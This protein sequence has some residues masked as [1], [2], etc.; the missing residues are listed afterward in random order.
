MIKQLMHVLVAATL[1][2]A[3]CSDRTPDSAKATEPGTKQSAQ[4]SAQSDDP[5]LAKQ[6]LKVGLEKGAEW[7]KSRKEQEH[8]A[9][10]EGVVVETPREQT[11]DSGEKL[12]ERDSE[13]LAT[14]GTAQAPGDSPPSADANASASSKAGFSIPG[15]NWHWSLW[16]IL[17]VLVIIL[18]IVL[19]HSDENPHPYKAGGLV[20][21]FVAWVCYCNDLLTGESF[22]MN[23]SI[24]V[25]GLVVYLLMGY[26]RAKGAFS[27]IANRWERAF[28]KATQKYIEEKDLKGPDGTRVEK[29]PASYR[30]DFQQNYWP[31][32]ARMAGYAVEVPEM[33]AYRRVLV[34]RGLFWIFDLI[35]GIFRRFLRDLMEW[36]VER[37]KS[38]CDHDTRKIQS[39]LDAL[40]SADQQA[41]S[42]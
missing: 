38:F 12:E 8:S 39:K 3:G 30:V 23:L 31:Q 14:A 11:P 4:S 37:L 25:G 20:L 28:K 6:A 17:A 26:P 22:V 9:S 42:S 33:R 15:T 32:Y 13:V 40:F 1:L 24:L 18:V 36:A 10:S 5:S 7:L 21:L 19:T 41:A 27:G 34:T 2:L 35:D 29:I 16:A